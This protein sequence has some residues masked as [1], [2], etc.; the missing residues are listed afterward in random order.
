[1]KKIKKQ[2]ET[3]KTVL[4]NADSGTMN[5]LSQ[6]GV[7]DLKDDQNFKFLFLWKSDREN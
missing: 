7:K 2:G 4:K 5:S 3:E 1:M 6:C